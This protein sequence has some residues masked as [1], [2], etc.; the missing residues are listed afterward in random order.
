MSASR[1]LHLRCAVALACALAAGTTLAQGGSSQAAVATAKPAPATPGDLSREEKRCH[2]GLRRVD[3]QREK[4][5]QT[6]RAREESVKAAETCGT[7]RACERSAHRSKSL[8]ARERQE[9]RQLA[10]L[11]AEARALCDEAA[12]AAAG[13]KSR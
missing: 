1:R 5:A 11:E 13:A 4:L 8:D 10:K 9:E 7:P 6:H 3:R 12:A 2:A